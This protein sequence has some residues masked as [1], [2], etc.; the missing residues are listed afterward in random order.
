MGIPVMFLGIRC[1]LWLGWL[2]G[3]P[4]MV[5][6]LSRD[7]LSCLVAVCRRFIWSRL[8]IGLARLRV[9]GPLSLMLFDGRELNIGH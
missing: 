6:G 9:G 4:V 7:K 1:L 3:W 8:G 2:T 5:L